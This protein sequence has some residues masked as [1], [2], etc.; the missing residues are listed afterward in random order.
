MAMFIRFIQYLA[1][2]EVQKAYDNIKEAEALSNGDIDK[3]LRSQIL[4]NRGVA[5]V[6]LGMY[7]DADEHL[8]VQLAI[9]KSII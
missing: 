5:Y 6:Q 1:M 9:V 2:G 8:F 3:V 4:I 7:Q